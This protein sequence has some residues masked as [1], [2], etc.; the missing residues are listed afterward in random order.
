MSLMNFRITINEPIQ[1]CR[2]GYGTGGSAPGL[3]LIGDGIYQ[4]SYVL[5][6]A[7]ARAYRIYDEEFKPTYNG[8]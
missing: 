4:C 6:K 3:K 8:S 7:H 2:D 5:L 1:I